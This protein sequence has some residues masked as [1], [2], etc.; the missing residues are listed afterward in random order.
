MGSERWAYGWSKGMEISM[1]KDAALV[2]YVDFCVGG[3]M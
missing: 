2:C 3:V 1:S